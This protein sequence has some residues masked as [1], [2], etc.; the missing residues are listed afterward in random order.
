MISW[1]QNSKLVYQVNLIGGLAFLGF[2]I[3]GSIFIQS[4]AKLE[5]GQAEISQDLKAL[6][7]AKDI[8]YQFLNARRNEKDF[9]LRF[10]QKY[11]DRHAKTM[12]GIIE[13]MNVL[14][15]SPSIEAQGKF[16]RIVNM[17]MLG[18]GKKFK[19]VTD[20]WHE[21][22][23][24]QKEGLRGRLRKSVQAVE[25]K[26]K[27]FKNDRLTVTMLMM[28]RHEKDFLLRLDPKYVK[29][30]DA[31]LAEFSG[32]LVQSNIPQAD[33]D[34]I[35][36]MLTS[37]LNDFKM[38][39]AKRLEIQT[40][41]GG[42][43]KI[44]SQ[45]QKPFEVLLNA[46]VERTNNAEVEME[47]TLKST[48]TKILS[49]IAVITILVLGLGVMIS[50]K[51]TQPIQ[52]LTD[53]MGRLAGGEKEI[54]IPVTKRKN[55][56]GDMGRAV[57]VFQ[58]NM[59][60]ADRLAAEQEESQKVQNDRAKQITEMT[61]VFEH[62][63]ES[64]LTMVRTAIS[65]M[66]STADGMKVSADQL[67]IRSTA[68][69][70]AALEA[71]SNVQT[72]AS[73]SEELAASIQEI[74]TQAA[75]STRI[76]GEAVVKVEETNVTVSGLAESAQRIGAAI[77]LINDIAD[78][79][80]LL[81]L[82]ATIEAARAGDAGKGFAVVASEVKNLANQTASATEEI[83]KQIGDVQKSTEEAVT[84]ISGISSVINQV[85]E[86]AAA[87]AAAVEEQ[88]AATHEIAR[89]VEQ[90][91][92]GTG[93]VTENIEGVSALATETEQAANDVHGASSQVQSQSDAMNEFIQGF[94]Q[95]VR[96][97]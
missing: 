94:L 57:L 88:M 45:A 41:I 1:F 8:H 53:A 44:F 22:G 70:S 78:Q 20:G 31:R 77:S 24:N 56:L 30:M 93:E 37:Y 21:I 79:T 43:S 12:A 75:N 68:V 3:I 69:S 25:E 90:A 19:N 10:D 16:V 17:M 32:D 36:E 48:K 62:D 95:K 91:S 84:A 67:N 4:E 18:Y 9:L 27:V 97:V 85:D 60:T 51:I 82:N 73:A 5:A 26:L 40:A 76:A 6:E 92:N 80:N 81:A 7:I 86:I 39:A 89:N 72:V 15:K 13:N 29:R 38:L 87:I 52:F 49:T 65:Q 14:A 83:S 58:E 35:M 47:H 63:S 42:L 61:A 64:V 33:A 28:R 2:V 66:S 23:L 11:I 54:E 34:E 74:G 46:I 71:S 50:R 96:A 59:I 55:E